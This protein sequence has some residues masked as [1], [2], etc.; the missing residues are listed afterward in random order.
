MDLLFRINDFFEDYATAIERF[1][2]KSLAHCYE[3]PCSFLSDEHV[4]AFTDA[5]QLEGFFSK[6]LSFYKMNG[7][8]IARPEVWHK[9][10]LTSAIIKTK[11]HWHYYNETEKL[12]YSCTYY[13]LLRQNPENE[14]K[15][16]TAISVNEK[17]RMEQGLRR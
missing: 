12:L 13:Y 9:E 2:A 14:L 8:T 16:V 7:I 1:N 11:L 5:A 17:E 4:T 3:L 6:G 10:R 15:I